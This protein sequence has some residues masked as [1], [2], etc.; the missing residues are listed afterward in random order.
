MILSVSALLL[1][2]GYTTI[3]TSGNVEELKI[4]APPNIEERGWEVL[5]YEGHKFGSWNKHGGT[6]WY[7]VRN[8]E[9]HSIQYRVQIA[10]WGGELQYYYGKPEELSRFN[11][12]N[13][14]LKQI[15]K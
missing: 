12:D 10:L 11:I 8:T 1:L 13:G 9:N 5:R 3:G 6:V 2:F 14:I 4:L 7:H 15:T